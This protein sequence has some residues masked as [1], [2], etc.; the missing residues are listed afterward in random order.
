MANSKVL[1]SLFWL[2]V[3]LVLLSFAFLWTSVKT[4]IDVF[5]HLKNLGTFFIKR[6]SLKLLENLKCMLIV[7]RF[8][9]VW[10]WDT[11]LRFVLNLKNFKW[12]RD[13]KGHLVLFWLKQK[14]LYIERSLLL[15]WLTIPYC[16][17]NIILSCCSYWSWN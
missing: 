6:I 12:L 15:G 3:W 5:R 4:F 16:W 7:G 10:L 14:H 17:G 11:P 13:L 1:S 9:F 2:L 8:L